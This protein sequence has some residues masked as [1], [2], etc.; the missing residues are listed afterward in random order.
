MLEWP[1]NESAFK[2][3][4]QWV[5]KIVF[6]FLL[7]VTTHATQTVA[8]SAWRKVCENAKIDGQQKAVCLTV[9][10]RLDGDTGKVRYSAAIREI[11]G[12]QDKTL[13]VMLPLGTSLRSGVKVVIYSRAE[14]NKA[15]R[16]SGIDESLQ[17]SV[18]LKFQLCHPAGCTAE[19]EA[20]ESLIKDME[21]G[22]GLIALAINSHSKPMGFPIPLDGFARALHGAPVDR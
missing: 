12:R 15:A 8:G 6:L 2:P 19:V 21:S 14:W 18:F 11:E 9:Y 7:F 22:A 10:E 5:A 13:M 1:A 3:P 17:K 4:Y 16:K 20:T